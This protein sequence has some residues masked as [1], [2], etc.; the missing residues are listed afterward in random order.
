MV[1]IFIISNPLVYNRFYFHYRCCS[2]LYCC[3]HCFAITIVSMSIR[4]S[5][6]SRSS[7]VIDIIIRK[8]IITAIPM[9]FK[10]PVC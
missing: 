8:V 7:I 3:Y 9:F 2:R 1:F 5:S 4:I 10:L 6:A